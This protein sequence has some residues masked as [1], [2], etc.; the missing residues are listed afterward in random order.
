[1]RTK[2]SNGWT[3]VEDGLFKDEKG[4]FHIDVH[5]AGQ[6]VRRA[7]NTDQREKAKELRDKLSESLWRQRKLGEAPEITW[8]YAV[9][10]EIER[11]YAEGN[12]SVFRAK[13]RLRRLHPLF[14]GKTLTEIVS[15]VN[16][17]QGKV[18][19]D[20]LA[21]LR[22]IKGATWNRYRSDVLAVLNHARRELGGPAV[23]YIEPKDEKKGK[24]GRR[25]YLRDWDQ[26]RALLAELPQNPRSNMRRCAHFAL[27]TGLREANVLYFRK[28][29][30]D[31]VNRIA[32]IPASEF[33]SKHDF[34]FPIADAALAIINETLAEQ[35]SLTRKYGLPHTDYL[36]ALARRA[37]RTWEPVQEIG[38]SWEAACTRIGLEDFHFHDL[39]HTWASWHVMNGTG[40]YELKDLGGWESIEMVQRYAH[41]AKNH[42]ARLA[43]NAAT[44]GQGNVIPLQRAA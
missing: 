34:E 4:R 12:R 28:S 15:P 3:E 35:E 36:F 9:E 43:N 25:R 26:A 29:W 41:L 8:D 27:V 42:L 24:H 22:G 40:L 38:S 2:R 44:F 39:R 20:A 6:R 37:R 23:P 33:K 11:K 1:M 31:L 21:T 13:D 14:T 30:L 18:I 16:G 32:K 7:C 19:K 5:V 17:V 10:R